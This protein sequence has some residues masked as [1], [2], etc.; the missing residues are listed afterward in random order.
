LSFYEKFKNKTELHEDWKKKST[1]RFK[2]KGFKPSRFKSY[3]KG[4]RMSLPAKSVYQQNSPSQSG[5]KPFGVALGK[6]DNTKREPLKYWGCGEEHLLRGFTY[7][8]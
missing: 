3:G 2:K 1:S 4:Y 5:N 7:R 8:K 6:H